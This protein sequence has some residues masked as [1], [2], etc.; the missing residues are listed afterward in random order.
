M[1]APPLIG[2]ASQLA[3]LRTALL[4]LVAGAGLI[5]LLVRSGVVQ[6]QPS[7]S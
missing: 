6:A 2:L 4:L 5:A 3:G 1:A 7:P